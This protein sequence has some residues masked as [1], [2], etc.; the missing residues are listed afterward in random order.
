MIFPI[1][2]GMILVD[3]I[4]KKGC[5]FLKIRLISILMVLALLFGILPTAGAFDDTDGHWAS[6]YIDRVVQLGLFTGM[7]ENEFAP[8]TTMSRAMFVTVLGRYEGIDPEY[9]SGETAPKFFKQDVDELAYYA[10]YVSWAVCNGIV[11]G[12]NDMLF[13]P[14]A[15]VTREQMAKMIAYYVRSMGHTLTE[16]EDAPQCFDDSAKISEW[17]YESVEMLRT[18]GILNGMPNEE[19]G[20]D[21]CPQK[22]ATRAEAAAVFCRIEE[23]VC[24]NE[25]PPILPQSL[26]LSFYEGSLYTGETCHLVATTDIEGASVIWRSSDSSILQVDQSGLVTCVGVGYATISAYTANG[27]YASCHFFCST[28]YPSADMSKSDKC[29]FVFGVDV[30]EPRYYYNSYEDALADMR[31]VTLYVWDINSAGEKYTKTM[32]IKVHKNLANTVIAIFDEI[33]HGEEKFPICY[34]GGFTWSGK[35]EHSIGT[36]IDINFPQNYY[37]DPDGNAIVGDYWKPYE[38]P[39]SIPPDGDLVRAFEKYGFSWG[40]NWNSGYKDYM[41][42]SFFGT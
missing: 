2:C 27:L 18:S 21:F 28:V 5:C 30:G 26:S 17:A 42:F 12:M 34:L 36:A 10:P 41:H 9:W 1:F 29:K 3:I 35:S 20:V 19:G 23:L 13:A 14:D 32:K 24:K 33:Y 38:D 11:N 40:I 8:D 15:P 16:A 25:V 22:T 31:D 7:S 37:C 4:P 6:D 39:Y